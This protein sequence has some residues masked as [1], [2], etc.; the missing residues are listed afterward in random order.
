MTIPACFKVDDDRV[1][2]R[3]DRKDK[4]KRYGVYTYDFDMDKRIAPN[5]ELYFQVQDIIEDKYGQYKPVGNFRYIKNDGICCAMVDR[6]LYN[7]EIMEE[8]GGSFN[9]TFTTDHLKCNDEV[10]LEVSS[11]IWVDLK[12]KTYADGCE[13]YFEKCKQ[14]RKDKPKCVGFL[15]NQSHTCRV[16]KAEEEL[17][18]Y[19]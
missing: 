17:A 6:K 7:I 12:N 2:E 3:F 14:I 11:D 16:R 19:L 4:N 5:Y 1:N 10:S 18:P 9:E 8:W 15:K 13:K